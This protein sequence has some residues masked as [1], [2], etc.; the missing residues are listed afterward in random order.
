MRTSSVVSGPANCFTV[1]RF[2]DVESGIALRILRN[3]KPYTPNVQVGEMW[4]ERANAD[5]CRYKKSDDGTTAVVHRAMVTK[6]APQGGR[7]FN[8]LSDVATEVPPNV[9]VRVSVRNPYLKSLSIQGRDLQIGTGTRGGRMVLADG[10][11]KLVEVPNGQCLI[12]FFDDG[13]V[14]AFSAENSALVEVSLTSVEMM[15]HRIADAH[16]QLADEE[17]RWGGPRQNVQRAII[18]KML[19]LFRLTARYGNHEGQ[20]LR[21]KLIREFFQRVD[22]S[23]IRMMRAA[24]YSTVSDTDHAL[25]PM[26][27]GIGDDDLPSGVTSLDAKRRASQEEILTPQQREARRLENIRLNDERLKAK[28]AR[29]AEMKVK[30]KATSAP[31]PKKEEKKNKHNKKASQQEEQKAA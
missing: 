18:G 28:K 9:L 19:D 17:A 1:G 14:R 15:D 7:P 6:V 2:G 4:I 26:V 12:V 5:G 27:Y 22:P 20:D 31:T 13:W 21:M 10:T 16:S 8:V 23:T 11:E 29:M 30:R 24:L 3:G 25:T